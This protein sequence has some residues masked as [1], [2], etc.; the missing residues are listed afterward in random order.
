NLGRNL[1]LA[2]CSV[3]CDVQPPCPRPDEGLR[4]PPDC[5]QTLGETD[6][7]EAIMPI[8]VGC[9]Q[10]ETE[11]NLADTLAGKKIRCKKCQ[12]V[13]PVPAAAGE[14]PTAAAAE[15]SDRGDAPPSR[16]GEKKAGK[17]ASRTMLLVLLGGGVLLL[18]LC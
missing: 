10:C 7:G 12:A 5:S 14:G 6:L 1:Q 9:S 18:G 11:H 17:G 3:G 16:E 2:A 15:T 13:V 8:R 4:N